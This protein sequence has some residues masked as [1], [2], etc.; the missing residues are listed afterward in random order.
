MIQSQ[1]AHNNK[2]EEQ[3]E[4]LRQQQF[5]EVQNITAGMQKGIE[6]RV[7]ELTKAHQSVLNE[8]HRKLMERDNEILKLKGKIT[9]LLAR[10]AEAEKVIIFGS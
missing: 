2:L 5:A 10:L 7:I 8:E 6:Q 4:V 1:T 3:A 9:E